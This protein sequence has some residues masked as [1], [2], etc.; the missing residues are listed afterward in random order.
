[1]DG[2]LFRCVRGIRAHRCFS[3][4]PT[5]DWKT[6]QTTGKRNLLLLA[7]N[8]PPFILRTMASVMPGLEFLRRIRYFIDLSFWRGH[9]NFALTR[10][11]R[12]SETWRF[13]M[14]ERSLMRSRGRFMPSRVSLSSLSYMGTPRPRLRENDG[15]RVFY[16]LRS[17]SPRLMRQRAECVRWKLEAAN[18]W[19][20]RII[21]RNSLPTR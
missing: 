4:T 12:S 10:K 5:G 16:A 7:G 9:F 11:R 15:A 3:P 6:T 19:Q 2:E 17:V 14:E 18:G 13:Q 8:R 20:R 21:R 1:M